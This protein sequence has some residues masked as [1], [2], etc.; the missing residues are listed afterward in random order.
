MVTV[1]KQLTLH[2]PEHNATAGHSS[3]NVQVYRKRG[4]RSFIFYK[5]LENPL[6]ISLSFFP[7]KEVCTFFLSSPSIPFKPRV[8]LMY[9]TFFVPD[10]FLMKLILQRDFVSQPMVRR[11]STCVQLQE[12]DTAIRETGW[13]DGWIQ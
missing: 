8:P 9:Y 4:G 2:Y 3:M 6:P 7:R 10:K 5:T 13:I 12:K 11:T 1:A